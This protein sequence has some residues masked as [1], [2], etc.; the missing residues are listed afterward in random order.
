MGALEIILIVACVAIVAGVTVA[1]II[2]KRKGKSPCCDECSG[3][4]GCCSHC[5]AV[6]TDNA[7]GDSASTDNVSDIANGN[8][9]NTGDNNDGAGTDNVAD[10]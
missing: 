4:C 7:T 1:A 10:K 8:D 3:N 5:A 2:R 9:D 6:G